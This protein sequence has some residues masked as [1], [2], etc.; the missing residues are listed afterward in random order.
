MDSSQF[1]RLYA[2][3][4]SVSAVARHLGINQGT[5]R[6]RL[7]KAGVEIPRSGFRSPK[8]KVARGVEHHNWKG[9]TYRQAD[10]YVYEYAP[11]HPAA[12]R[13]KGY[14][15]QHRLV[16]ERSLGRYLTDAETVHHLNEDKADNRIENLEVLTHS[17]HIRGHK[18]VARRDRHGRFTTPRP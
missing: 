10:G 16:V 4:G 7:R 8:S 18:A 14:V 9:G 11:D 5:L 17:A 2:E 6:Y 12:S 3:Y 13:A 15:L 1:R